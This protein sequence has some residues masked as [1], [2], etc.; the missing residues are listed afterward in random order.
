[1]H[2]RLTGDNVG[3]CRTDVRHSFWSVPLVASFSFSTHSS[4]SG[5]GWVR[6]VCTAGVGRIISIT[7]EEAA[8]HAAKIREILDM[9]L[10]SIIMS[11][12]VAVGPCG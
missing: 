12:F 8:Q 3:G 7:A 2:P 1:M 4:V 10:N 6:F 11:Y 5:D 9:V